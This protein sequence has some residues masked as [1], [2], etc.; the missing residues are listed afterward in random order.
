MF[1]T[2]RNIETDALVVKRTPFADADWV[3]E[4][5]TAKLGKVTAP[6]ERVMGLI[7]LGTST[8]QGVKRVMGGEKDHQGPDE[9]DW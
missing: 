6:M 1:G 3:V 8:I 4:L 7:G 2:G 5:F 9:D